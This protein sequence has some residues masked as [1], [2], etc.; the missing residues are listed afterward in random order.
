MST[1]PKIFSN[2]PL[3]EVVLS[4]LNEHCECTV[5]DSET[6][7]SR[8]ELLEHIHEY[9]G[10]IMT[11]VPVDAELL[12]R[13][14]KLRAV[15]TVSVGYNHFDLEVMQAKGIIGTH[16]PHV[17]D[18]T[19]ADLVMALILSAA[20]R[21]AELDAYVKQGRWTSGRI[22]EDEWFGMDV[23]HATLGIIG[24]G[25]IGEVIAK[26][27]V[28]GFDMELLY[29]N[30]SRNLEA[31]KT[32]GARY[33]SLEQLLRESDF[34]LLMAPLTPATVNYIRQEHF[35]MMKSSAFFINA[36]RGQ[37]VDEQALIEALRNGAIRGAGLDVFV[38]E[39]VAADNALLTLPNVVTVPHIGSATAKTRTDMAMLA[40]QNLVGA[41]TGGKAHVVP[42]LQALV[43]S[44]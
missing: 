28:R 43:Q 11:G 2:R 23:H 34:V 13:A 14:A 42:E 20:R 27:A 9:E 6:P 37:T 36:S 21:I 26:R 35:E 29:H 19:V 16:T 5:W 40:A 32:Y 33:C 22:K 25:R 3:P 30:R 38:Q 4:Y 1:K 17:L 8:S 24:L 39:P 18:D 12:E 10:L 7:L 15:S 31:E 41:L 44:K